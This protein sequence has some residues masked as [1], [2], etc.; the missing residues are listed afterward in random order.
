METTDC[1]LIQ[2]GIERGP[3][4]PTFRNLRFQPGTDAHSFL[5][6]RSPRGHQLW[7]QHVT[8]VHIARRLVIGKKRVPNSRQRR[9][10]RK[11][12]PEGLTLRPTLLAGDSR[13]AEVPS[14]VGGAS[15]VGLVQA[16]E[17]VVDEVI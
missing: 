5:L 10:L 14:C 7:E 17:V 8:S 4:A 1:S 2:Y 3:D 13:V 9:L 15:V 16:P 6:V 12:G 11:K